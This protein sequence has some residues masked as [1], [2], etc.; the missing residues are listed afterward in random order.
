MQIKFAKI[1]LESN[2]GHVRYN[3]KKLF[4]YLSNPIVVWS[5]CQ[6]PEKSYTTLPT[7]SLF[8]G[9]SCVK[10]TPVQY[11]AENFEK[12]FFDN[13]KKNCKKKKLTLFLYSYCQQ[14]QHYS[15][16]EIKNN[17]HFFCFFQPCCPD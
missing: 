1:S 8:N 10:P 4:Q 9:R 6:C 16:Y 11:I 7:C 15:T 17:L 3:S 5:A 14:S 2:L 13:N 12:T